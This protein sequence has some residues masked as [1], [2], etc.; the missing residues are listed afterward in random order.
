MTMF[1]YL[2]DLVDLAVDTIIENPIKT[3][4]VVGATVATGGVAAFAAPAIGAATSAAGF[5]AAA[6]TLSGAA[7]SSAGLAA[8]GGVASGVIASKID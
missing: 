7:A 4:A 2:C 3:I 8:W 1:S 5:G 6:T